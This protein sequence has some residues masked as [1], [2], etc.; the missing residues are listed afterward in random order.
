[1]CDPLIDDAGVRGS[2]TFD[3]KKELSILERTI[4]DLGMLEHHVAFIEE[5][6][7]ENIYPLGLKTFVPCAVLCPEERMEENLTCNLSRTF[8]S[9][10]KAL[11]QKRR[12]I[13]EGISRSESE[14]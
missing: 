14:M 13:E 7:K 9:M 10:Q 8:S 11:K 3:L 12:G 4:S 5:C 1:M 6:M 2:E